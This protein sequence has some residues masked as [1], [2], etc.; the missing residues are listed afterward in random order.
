MTIEFDPEKHIYRLDG[1]VVPSV[2][3]IMESAGL[4]QRPLCDLETLE[5][6][7]QR[8]VAVHKAINIICGGQEP[9]GVDPRIEGYVRAF[10]AFMQESRFKVI[11]SEIVLA[12]E[13]HRYAGTADL[14]GWWGSDRALVDVK[15]GQPSPL[16]A[17]QLAGYRMLWRENFQDQRI[18]R[19]MSLWVRE[20]GSY[21]LD[22]KEVFGAESAFQSA[23][24]IH[25][26]KESLK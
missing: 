9:Q 3:Q 21:R 8:G 5:I 15:T 4:S 13:R 1:V 7:R 6:A 22:E 16:V 17:V 19:C 24:N 2:T 12:S 18:R 10:R 25:R 20:D 26:Y 11:R 23:L 14:V